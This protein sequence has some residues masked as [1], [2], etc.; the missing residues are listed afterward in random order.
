MNINPYR[1]PC[2]DV[3]VIPKLTHSPGTVITRIDLGGFGACFNFA[4]TQQ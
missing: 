3:I 4:S 1:F 2:I